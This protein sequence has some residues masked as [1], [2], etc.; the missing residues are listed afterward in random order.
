MLPPTNP[1]LIVPYF[2]LFVVQGITGA[3]KANLLAAGGR[4]GPLGTVQMPRPLSV[5]SPVD[6]FES[7]LVHEPTPRIE[8]RLVHRPRV[9]V[10]VEVDPV[11]ARPRVQGLP[12]VWDELPPV[13][14]PREMVDTSNRFECAFHP[15]IAGTG[16]LI[17]QFL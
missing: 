4:E 1:A 2:D 15:A 11:V 10:E 12:R 5:D 8:P 7:R 13:Q 14:Q 9:A 6:R 17:D 3:I 16:T